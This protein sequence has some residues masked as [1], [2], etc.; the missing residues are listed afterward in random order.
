MV[1]EY[2]SVKIYW[3]SVE[4]NWF[5]WLKRG[6]CESVKFPWLLQ[7]KLTDSTVKNIF[8]VTNQWKLTYLT[9]K[10]VSFAGES[11]KKQT[12][13]SISEN[14]TDSDLESG[15]IRSY[16]TAVVNSTAF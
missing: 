9:V 13:D 3:L 1:S 14:L 8:S 2:K 6:Y 16:R 5:K 12:S 11:M 10:Y 7:W 4:F 15:S